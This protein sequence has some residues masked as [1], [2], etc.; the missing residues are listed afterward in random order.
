MKIVL[1]WVFDHLNASVSDFDPH[2]ILALLTQKTV[3]I[4]SMEK[5]TRNI[6]EFACAQII[7]E[8]EN[9]Y[10][11]I[12]HLSRRE[13]I[14]KAEN[15]KERFLGN[16]Y[17]IIFDHEIKGWRFSTMKD[18]G[19]ER[20][21]LLPPLYIKESHNINLHQLIP[22]SE[23]VFTIDNN[24]ISHRPDLWCHRGFARELSA[25]LNVPLKS[26]ESLVVAK[27]LI[28]HVDSAPTSADFPFS[29]TLENK[30]ACD[31][32]AGL[33]VS[34]IIC[35][36]SVFDMAARLCLVDCKPIDF[37][38]DATN[39]V[40]FD[41]GQ[42]IHIYDAEILSEKRIVIRNADENSFLTLLDGQTI[43]LSKDDLIIAD[44]LNPIALAGIMGGIHA[45]VTKKTTT[46]FVES[47]HFDALIIR[48][49][50]TKFHRKTE[51]SMRFSKNIDPN[52]NVFGITRYLMLLEQYKIPHKTAS[53][54]ESLGNLTQS[55]KITIT[56]DFIE[57]KLGISL[58]AAKIRQIL[59]S[60][61]FDVHIQ[62]SIY[63]IIP[64]TFR[65]D[66]I[67]SEDV[68]EEVARMIG[69]DVIIRTLPHIITMPKKCIET[70]KNKRD[71]K[72]LLSFGFLMREIC[73]YALFDE[74]FL[75]K[76]NYN[77]QHTVFLKNPISSDKI[78]LV[79]TLLI[80]IIKT[81]EEQQHNQE[82]LRFYEMARVWQEKK[83]GEIHEQ[84]V[85]SGIFFEK[86][87]AIDFYQEKQF[88]DRLFSLLNLKVSYK[89]MA[90][91]LS[92]FELYDPIRSAIIMHNDEII[93]HCGI[94]NPSLQ[95]LFDK[96]NA[97]LFECN[98]KIMQHQEIIRYREISSFPTVQRD[99][100]LLLSSAHTTE[101][102]ISYFYSSDSRIR[103]V[104]IVDIFQKKEWE[105]KRAVTF[106]FIIEDHEKTL[107]SQEIDTLFNHITHHLTQKGI[108]IR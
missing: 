11:I 3:E 105:N 68:L 50:S 47:A 43:T 45:K 24:A 56:Q 77:P 101:D 70:I 28:S 23:I 55:N 85:L 5:I 37:L 8:Q 4:E 61:G 42:P 81:T 36:P 17:L 99:V 19:S 108:E 97:F 9:S 22:S 53:A 41:I 72:N 30:S 98:T 27:K 88:L 64:G 94:I 40:L 16:T 82:S 91:E 62:G 12:D 20:D 44:G 106:R 96:G 73:T 34:Q 14:R 89:I 86:K 48:K 10:S 102:L 51:S 87:E 33:F 93:G 65:T 32:F 58:D 66:L 13:T 95:N 38:V 69:Y 21:F 29:I 6:D 31:R 26:L 52:Q 100:S 35:Q 15:T 80:N 74:S 79:S 107:T 25:I 92:E 103:T 57:K 67:Q 2:H 90:A 54:I 46:L 84:E 49:S 83:P 78:R 1:S 60:L 7:E 63:T 76:I 104:S 39:V 71:V 59:I 75:K 18:L